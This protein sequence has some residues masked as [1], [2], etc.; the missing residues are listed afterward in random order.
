MDVLHIG[1][2]DLLPWAANACKI[3]FGSV[4]NLSNYGIFFIKVECCDTVEKN[5]DILFIFGTVIRTFGLVTKKILP[6]C[7][8]L[9]SQV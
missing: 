8:F 7:C 4:L 1:Y 6:Y 9:T 5:L 3:E 2:N